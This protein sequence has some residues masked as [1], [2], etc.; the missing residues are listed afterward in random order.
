MRR[1][2]I[3]ALVGVFCT[4]LFGAVIAWDLNPGDWDWVWR[5]WCTI[6]AIFWAAFGAGISEGRR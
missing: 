4:Y 5:S 6:W 2:L 3:G 1:E